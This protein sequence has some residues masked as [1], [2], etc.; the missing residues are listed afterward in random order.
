MR[1]VLLITVFMLLACAMIAQ[2]LRDQLDEG[3]KLSTAGRYDEAIVIFSE[4]LQKQPN[5]ATVLTRRAI[6]YYNNGAY[7][8][9]SVDLA[10]ATSLN[11]E[12]H[13]AWYFLGKIDLDRG[14]YKAAI[15]SLDRAISY[16][17]GSS[18]Y[19]LQRGVSKYQLAE[20]EG[21][22]IDF[23][24]SV[25]L[26]GTYWGHIWL[27]NSELMLG[28]YA[29]SKASYQAALDLN[30]EEWMAYNQMGLL[31]SKLGDLQQALNYY[32]QSLNI[33][34]DSSSTHSNLAALENKL[35]NHS[36]AL[37]HA[38]DALRLQNSNAN[39]HAHKSFAL[40][41]LGRHS[42][43]KESA[44]TAISY[45][46]TYNQSYYYL[47]LAE[48]SL[49]HLDVV[50]SQLLKALDLT[51]SFD[52]FYKTVN[53]KLKD[54]RQKSEENVPPQ[55]IITNP[56]LSKSRG[57]NVVKAADFEVSENT[58]WVE[59]TVKSSNGVK[60]LTVNE[61]MITFSANGYFTTDIPLN[62]GNNEVI[63]RCVDNRG[64]ES[65][66]SFTI[67][68]TYA[69]KEEPSEPKVQ[70]NDRYYA[71]L[72]GVDN[73]ED[74]GIS[75]L[76]KPIIDAQKVRGV[77]T[78]KYGFAPSDVF[79]LTD[80]DRGKF[81]SVLENIGKI[82]RPDDNLLIF[83]AGHGYWDSKYDAGYWLLSDAV[84]SNRSSWLS[85]NELKTLLNGLNTRHT[86]VIA[87][88]CYSG[89][90]IK[91]R[92]LDFG[93]ELQSLY[94]SKSRKAM[95]SGSLKTVPDESVFLY[96]LI[97]RLEGNSQKYLRAEYLFNSL[98]DEVMMNT[99][100]TPLY[101]DIPSLTQEGGDFLFKQQ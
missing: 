25:N 88:A 2:S 63:V 3:V 11:A 14:S 28:D 92:D 83:Y 66:T 87:D 12:N 97:K 68:S 32:Q 13:V 40:W 34:Q 22:R 94:A 82:I 5:S 6:A 7:N 59:G 100:N 80:P 31:N 98:R 79:L 38:N 73:Y 41:N 9:A 90:L 51:P 27:G 29:S 60:S 65:Q 35:G 55:I 101:G 8:N 52:P 48:E 81:Y 47:A 99:E 17:P 26:N 76:A 78:E 54:F 36:K 16:N 74:Y 30:G 46:E 95:T 86:L 18:E 39:A 44:E 37:E 20:Y 43:S 96:Y 15:N 75:D 19:F 1:K 53:D 45:D 58:L 62:R 61:Q 49:G 89:S 21:A 50:E 67:K 77:L 33:T 71:L 84:P 56:V 72:V 42:E 23:S 70:V 85:N 69:K 57:F 64:L 4:I 24:E 91:S 10:K 93:V